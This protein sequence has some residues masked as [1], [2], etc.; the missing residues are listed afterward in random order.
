MSLKNFT[1]AKEPESLSTFANNSP[2]TVKREC[3]S[4]FAK[5]CIQF[6][7]GMTDMLIRKM[8]ELDLLVQDAYKG[9]Q[10]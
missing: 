6:M 5:D 8:L 9:W 2:E 3:F 7:N 10:R 4:S 1:V